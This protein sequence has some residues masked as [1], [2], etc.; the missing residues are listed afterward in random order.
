MLSGREGDLKII[1]VGRSWSI[2]VP[3]INPLS[4]EP[5]TPP[6]QNQPGPYSL[7]DGSRRGDPDTPA[8]RN[9]IKE[10]HNG[11]LRKYEWR[12]TCQQIL[13]A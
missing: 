9:D 11:G 4:N 13:S 8:L 3:G 10:R 2:L 7:H 12:K 5:G 6:E 1:N